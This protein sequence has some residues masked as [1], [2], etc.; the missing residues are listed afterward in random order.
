MS[1]DE[2]LYNQPTEPQ[3]RLHHLPPGTMPAQAATPMP[4][5]TVAQPRTKRISR[6]AMMGIGAAVAGLG[7]GIAL[8]QYIQRGGLSSLLHGPA[9]SSIQT[10][11]LL[12]HAGF[13]ASA[14]DMVT[15]SS[16]G[17]SS[18]VDRLLNYPQSSA[19]DLGKPL[20]PPT[21]N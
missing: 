6:R 15:F 7:G 19:D 14:D 17:Y 8:E 21:C 4:A 18:A 20:K 13:G 12:R 9:A 16:L 5:S 10:G 11:H 1:L 3:G 2:D